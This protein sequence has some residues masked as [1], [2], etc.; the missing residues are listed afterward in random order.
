MVIQIWHTNLAILLVGRSVIISL[1]QGSYPSMLM[2]DHMLVLYLFLLFPFPPLFT[3]A[4][5]SIKINLLL[6]LFH[7]V[8]TS[9]LG[10]SRLRKKVHVSYIMV[11]KLMLYRFS[12]WYNKKRDLE[13]HRFSPSSPSSSSRAPLKFIFFLLSSI[14]GKSHDSSKNLSSI[15]SL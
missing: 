4:L 9:F 14:C 10:T 7:L 1:G 3:L 8:S 12:L 5:C 13:N 11:W 2:S 15:C 6:L